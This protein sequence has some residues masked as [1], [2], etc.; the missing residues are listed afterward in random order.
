MR[1]S[2]PLLLLAASAATVAAAFGQVSLSA[3]VVATNQ[4]LDGRMQGTVRLFA[5][6]VNSLDRVVTCGAHPSAP[7]LIF[8]SDPQGF[9]QHFAG[10]DLSSQIN[11]GLLTHF[12]ELA[13]DSWG[14]TLR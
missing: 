4:L 5:D 6:V 9:F 2:Q 11:P 3:D 12:A 7:M 13:Y 1:S 8:T 10:G 14:S